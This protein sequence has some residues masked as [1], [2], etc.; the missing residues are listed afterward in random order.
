[1]LEGVQR[2]LL[3]PRDRFAE[4][5]VAAQAGPQYD[6]VHQVADQRFQFRPAAVGHRRADGEIVL[7]AV[8]ASSTSNAASSTM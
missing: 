3:D 7:A 1:M 2:H 6:H 5:G 4:A 8:A